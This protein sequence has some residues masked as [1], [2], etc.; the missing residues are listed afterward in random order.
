MK[1]DLT[2]EIILSS[3]FERSLF[4]VHVDIDVRCTVSIICRIYVDTC[5]VTK[6]TDVNTQTNSGSSHYVLRDPAIIKRPI[7]KSR[8]MLDCWNDSCFLFIILNK[9]RWC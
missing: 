5:T 3:I 8:R 7:R 6:R 2:A 4:S 9:R 1:L